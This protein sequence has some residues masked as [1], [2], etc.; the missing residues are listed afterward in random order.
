VTDRLQQY[1]C[2]RWRI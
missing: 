2:S 1:S